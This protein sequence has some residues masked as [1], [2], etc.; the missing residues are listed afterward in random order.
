LEQEAKR[1]KPE[2]G[3]WLTAQGWQAY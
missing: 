3:Y 2:T 1:S